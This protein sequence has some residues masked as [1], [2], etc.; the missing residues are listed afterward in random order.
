MSSA[1][2]KKKK[3]KKKKR[4]AHFQATWDLEVGPKVH[5][6]SPQIFKFEMH[7]LKDPWSFK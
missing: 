7:C 5:V 2:K 6:L 1:G 4:N 3:E